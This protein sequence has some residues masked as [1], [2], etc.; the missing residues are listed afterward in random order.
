MNLD[1]IVW[2]YWGRGDESNRC[3][4]TVWCSKLLHVS[5]I[6]TGQLNLLQPEKK[7]D[8]VKKLEKDFLKCEFRLS[9]LNGISYKRSPKLSVTL[10][11][12]SIMRTSSFADRY[13]HSFMMWVWST[14]MVAGVFL[15]VEFCRTQ[16]DNAP[17]TIQL[18]IYNIAV[19]TA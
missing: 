1:I 15:F 2:W 11:S 12:E 4:K 19:A 17:A 8:Q 5:I 13:V 3:Q 14:N 16:N 6:H 7:I 9:I 10:M 18:K